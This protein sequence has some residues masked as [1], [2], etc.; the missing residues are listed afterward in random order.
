LGFQLSPPR[1]VDLSP[2]AERH[3]IE[4][5]AELLVPLLSDPLNVARDPVSGTKVAP[6][7]DT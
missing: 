5:L 2:E 6:V 7:G 1:F 3:A 4:A